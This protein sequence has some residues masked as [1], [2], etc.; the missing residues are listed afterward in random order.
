VGLGGRGGKALRKRFLLKKEAKTRANR[1]TLDQ[2]KLLISKS[3]LVLF[4]KKEP[5]LYD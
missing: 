3:F 1:R 2:R 5:L 4:F